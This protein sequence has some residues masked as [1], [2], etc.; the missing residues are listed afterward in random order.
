MPTLSD[1]AQQ[2]LDTLKEFPDNSG[3]GGEI[4]EATSMKDHIFKKAKVELKD[5]EMITLGRGRGGRVTLVEGAEPPAE[6]TKGLTK[7]DHMALAREEK[8]A[9]KAKKLQYEAQK[10]EALEA[11][12]KEFP[13]LDCEFHT[14]YEGKMYIEIK[15]EPGI[16]SEV[17]AY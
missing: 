7:A 1:E 10:K 3:T 9:K 17:K 2:I 6:E 15:T 14:F 12:K 11:A 4:K 16:R 8:E 13:D 5:A